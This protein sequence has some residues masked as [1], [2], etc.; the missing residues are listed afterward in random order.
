MDGGPFGFGG[1][2]R[3]MMMNN[4]FGFNPHNNNNNFMGNRNMNNN[5]M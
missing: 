4:N 2:D 5:N 3:N 1:Q